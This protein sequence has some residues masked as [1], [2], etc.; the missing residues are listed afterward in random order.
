MEKIALLL[1]YNSA[2]WWALIPEYFIMFSPYL[3]IN[4]AF[5]DILSFVKFSSILLFPKI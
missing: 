5:V 1:W 2:T 4:S 3:Q